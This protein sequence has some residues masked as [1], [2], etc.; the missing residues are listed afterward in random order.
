[1]AR[2]RGRSRRRRA[3]LRARRGA[4]G[5]T[6]SGEG[7]AGSFP[8]LARRS[9]Y[10]HGTR[11]NTCLTALGYAGAVTAVAALTALPA[12]VLTIGLLVRSPLGRRVVAAPKADRWHRRD[13]PLLGG[14]GIFAG[15]LVG[16]GVAVASGGVDASGELLGIVGGCA[17]L[18][19]A[20]LVDD[21]FT[22]PPAAKLA[23]QG[24]AAAVALA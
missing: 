5:R 17:I 20:G 2:S 11:P 9:T 7:R 14:V 24:G 19:V 22:L 16:V 6:D 8:R 10:R 4:T 21:V 3:P 13:T 23:A 15:L 18:F 12:S 1:S